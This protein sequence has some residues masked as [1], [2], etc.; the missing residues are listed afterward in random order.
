MF[1]FLVCLFWGHNLDKSKTASIFTAYLDGTEKFTLKL[2][3]CTRCDKFI[4]VVEV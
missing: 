1:K 4:R 3:P 2:H